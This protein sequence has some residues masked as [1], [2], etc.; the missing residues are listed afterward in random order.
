MFEFILVKSKSS[1]I[2]CTVLYLF[3]VLFE[4]CIIQFDSLI[5]MELLYITVFISWIISMQRLDLV[6]GRMALFFDNQSIYWQK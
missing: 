1:K 5:F 2:L 4:F 3:I 6:Q